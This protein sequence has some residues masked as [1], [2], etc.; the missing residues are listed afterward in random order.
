M[1]GKALMG[2]N[3]YCLE[4]LT[5]LGLMTAKERS[6]ALKATHEDIRAVG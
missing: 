3:M 1:Q 5:N 2:I 6:A 4:E